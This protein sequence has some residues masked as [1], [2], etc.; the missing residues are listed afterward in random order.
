MSKYTTIFL[1]L[2]DTLWDTR[3]NSEESMREIFKDYHFNEYYPDFEA[4]YEVYFEYNNKLWEQYRKGEISKDEL[5]IERLQYPFRPYKEFDKAFIYA[6]NDDFLNRTTEKTKLLPY[7]I[8]ILQYLRKK[9]K[10][11]ILS[12]G[13][14]EVQYKKMS[15]SGLS[16]F[17]EDVVLSDRIGAP[18]PSP[19]IFHEAMKVAGSS[20]EDT[21]M[22]GDNWD[23]DVVG[24]KGVGMDQIWYDIDKK[25]ISPFR[26]TFRIASLKEI[27]DIL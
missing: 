3:A 26:P 15:N 11:Y 6:L 7:A 27:I 10:L 4:F 16:P 8:E 9:Y 21:I 22:I 20:V 12:N 1:D 25:G 23:A 2:D 14:E 5:I 18:K 24:A 17:F 19:R 13:F